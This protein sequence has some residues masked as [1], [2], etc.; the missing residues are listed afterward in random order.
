MGLNHVFVFSHRLP[1]SLGFLSNV[2]R[3][4]VKGYGVLNGCIGL[5]SV[6]LVRVPGWHLYWFGK[7]MVGWSYI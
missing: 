6:L 1:Q 5:V 2:D 4:L 7:G 3:H